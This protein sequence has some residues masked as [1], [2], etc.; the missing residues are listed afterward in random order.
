[1]R[2]F[3]RVQLRDA[4]VIGRAAESAKGTCR[5]R[6]VV[7]FLAARAH[8]SAKGG[9]GTALLVAVPPAL[10]VVVLQSVV[11]FCE[12][13]LVMLVIAQSPEAACFVRGVVACL[14]ACALRSAEGGARATLLVAVVP[15]V[16][17][18]VVESSL[19][20][21]NGGSAAVVVLASGSAE[22]AC[23]GRGAVS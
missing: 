10:L 5:V 13:A 9:A 23:L 14:A 6:C 19:V 16:G 12:D 22:A 21:R 4:A 1:M 15:A 7:A 17:V 11:I 20:A 18:C 8:G 3:Q 2:R